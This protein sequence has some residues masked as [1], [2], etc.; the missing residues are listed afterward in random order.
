MIP[1]NWD[2]SFK[3]LPPYSKVHHFPN[4]VSDLSGITA[5]EQGTILYVS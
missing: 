2:F 5:K 4:G 3:G 1:F